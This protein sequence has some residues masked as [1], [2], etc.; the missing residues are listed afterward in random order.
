MIS[1]IFDFSTLSSQFGT[2]FELKVLLTVY[3][4]RIDDY[5]SR[6]FAASTVK[7][8]EDKIAKIPRNSIS[9]IPLPKNSSGVNAAAQILSCS[10]E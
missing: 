5:V 4:T 10:T 8:I 9:K 6:F 2:L 7:L 3:E 1:S